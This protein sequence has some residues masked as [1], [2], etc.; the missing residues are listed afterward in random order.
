MAIAADGYVLFKGDN[1][2]AP[3]GWISPD[4]IKYR[5]AGILFTK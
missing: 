1:N 3:D 4:R 2:Q 5:V